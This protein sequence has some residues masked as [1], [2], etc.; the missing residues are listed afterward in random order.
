MK[1]TCL[2]ACLLAAV[3]APCLAQ[4]DA[5]GAKDH[6]MFSRM[7]GYFID[8]YD[9]QD[10]SSLE[11]DL[12]PP[13]TVEGRYWSIEYDIKE[14]A[15]KIGPLQIARN[16]TDLIVKQGG[17]KL[18]EDVDASGGTSIA[19]WP[20]HGKNIWV[21]IKVSNHGEVFGLEV[22]EEAA[23]AQHVEFTATEL[24][25]ALKAKGSV[26]LHN[27][28]FD[29]GKSTLKLE[30]AA[31]LI[32]VGD[33]LR[34]DPSLKLEIQGHTDNVGGAAANLKLSQERAAAV[35]AHLVQTYG[36]ANDRLTTAGYGDT[37][38]IA[39]NATED[40]KSQNRRVEL[41]KK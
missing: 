37:R 19:Q 41:V 6:P 31:A 11:L 34:A 3:A 33:L 38:P 9:V 1:V 14:G 24:A 29:T 27:I 40:G 22:V 18:L 17:R 36:I 7:P 2:V 15:K 25:A 13:K 12:D 32:P 30:S 26:A 10:F 5:E 28:L 39:D 16:Y 4:D 8:E 35:R 23:M 21:Q 20:T